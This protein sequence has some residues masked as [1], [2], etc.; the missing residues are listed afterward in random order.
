EESLKVKENANNELTNTIEKMDGINKQIQELRRTYKEKKE[1][2]DKLVR[3]ISIYSEDV[4]LAELG[5]YEPHFNFEDSE[6]FKNKIKSIRDEQKLMLRDKTHSGA[7]Y[8]T[9]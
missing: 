1:I 6:Q 9:T 5:F 4:E 8:C 3:Q 7:V 2:Y